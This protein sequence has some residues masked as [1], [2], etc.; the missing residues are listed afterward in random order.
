LLRQAKC[1]WL[2]M[3]MICRARLSVIGWEWWWFVAPG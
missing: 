3:I 2:G 1:D